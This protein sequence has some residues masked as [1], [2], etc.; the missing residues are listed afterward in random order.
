MSVRT[1]RASSSGVR[2]KSSQCIWTTAVLQSNVRLTSLHST[3]A[4]FPTTEHAAPNT[5]TSFL[6]LPLHSVACKS[7]L[8]VLA[9]LAQIFSSCCCCFRRRCVFVCVAWR[10]GPLS[11][12][13]CLCRTTRL[14]F[15]T[16]LAHSLTHTFS[17]TL[18]FAFKEVAV[19]LYLA[20]HPVSRSRVR[21][22]HCRSSC[23]Y[24]RAIP[25]LRR[26]SQPR[27]IERHLNNFNSQRW[28][29]IHTGSG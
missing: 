16:I 18:N 8:P 22:G 20:T 6:I 19:A 11:S 29:W 21:R 27:N 23:R 4:T 9:S 25:Y 14:L 13:Y 28:T 1:V 12:V 10:C 26:R 15:A 7:T 2:E 5:T 3:A 24:T 17:R